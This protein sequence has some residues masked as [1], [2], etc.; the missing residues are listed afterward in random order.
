MTGRRT[1]LRWAAAL[2]ALAMLPGCVP[3]L[4]AGLLTQLPLPTPAAAPP[5]PPYLHLECTDCNS[6]TLTQAADWPPAHVDEK[7]PD[8]AGEMSHVADP[9]PE[10][11]TAEVADPDPEPPPA[12]RLQAPDLSS[13]DGLADRLRS[14]EGL[15]LT[16]YT[17]QFGTVHIGYG[18]RIDAAEAE[19]LLAEDLAE[20]RAAAER[21]VGADVWSRLDG[22]RREVLAE[23]AYVLGPTGLAKFHRMLTAVRAGQY[24]LAASELRDSAWAAQAP[25]RVDGLAARMATGAEE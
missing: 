14:A 4:L 23:A 5:P 10:P 17:D 6:L 1:P 13:D 22:V 24:E 19:Q 15:R 3:G 21:V 20:A 25:A 9:P 16:P 2:V 7:R 8:N 12:V 18:H 11:P